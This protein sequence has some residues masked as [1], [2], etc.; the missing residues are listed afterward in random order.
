MGANAP[1]NKK[2]YQAGQ[3]NGKWL[4]EAAG[5]RATMESPEPTGR[6]VTQGLG[7][8]RFPLR[9]RPVSREGWVGVVLCWGGEGGE[10]DQLT[11]MGGR[12][13][14]TSHTRSTIQCASHCSGLPQHNTVTYIHSLQAQ[15]CHKEEK[16]PNFLTK[17]KTHSEKPRNAE[18]WLSD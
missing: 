14:L 8:L 7:D 4:S 2:T 6:G 12:K 16:C 13:V 10:Q 18:A 5:H 1:I 17:T 9:A 15:E 3:Q 11:D